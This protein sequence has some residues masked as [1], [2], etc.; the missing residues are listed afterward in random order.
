MGHYLQSVLSWP[1][2]FDVMHSYG[3]LHRLDTPSSGLILTAK[4]YEAFYDLKYQLST[5]DLVRDY[6]V[7]C[8]GLVSPETSEI[9]GRVYH[10]RHE[11]NLPSTICR[12]GKPSRTCLK[13]AA[14][15]SKGKEIFTLVAVRI[16]TGR[17]HQIR[18]HFAH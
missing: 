2:A 5:G 4:T 9:Y 17:R 13:V 6:V 11:G 3:F 15:C 12:K 10:W 18:T 1:L 8:R 14:H 7:L 16:C